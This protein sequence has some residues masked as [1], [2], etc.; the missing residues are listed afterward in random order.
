MRA[1]QTLLGCLMFLAS[2]AGVSAEA[3]G[4]DFFR[5]TGITQDDV[6]NI[7]SDGNANAP[8]LG[9][10]P[11]GTDG[12]K[13]LGCTGGLSLED[14][15]N[16]SQA[17]RDAAA[18]T[19]WC[20]VSFDGVEGWA[21]GWFLVEGTAS[22]SDRIAPSFDCA[23]ASTSAEEAVCEDPHLARLD[24]ELARLYRL[25]VRGP[26]MTPDRLDDL[27]ASQRGWVKGRD[28]CWKAEIGLDRCIEDS[29]VMRIDDIRTG[30]GDARAEDSEGISVGPLAYAC[31]GLDALVSFVAVNAD[32]SMV[33]LRWRDVWL[34]GTAQPAGSGVRYE[35]QT[36]DGT[37]SFWIKGNDAQLTRPGQPDLACK[38]DDIG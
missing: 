29:Y 20:R 11:S 26:N 33:S 9:T 14:W 22:T 19:R 10:I 18:K 13:N 3:D 15:Q 7:R 34:V 6:L 21:A 25:A 2:S 5:V 8:I 17:E 16:A 1:T 27:K 23:K 28:A 35:D 31:D 36:A 32:P 24:L 4:P 38:V 30:Y 37:F 12:V